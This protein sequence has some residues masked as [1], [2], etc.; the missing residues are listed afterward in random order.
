MIEKCMPGI[1]KLDLEKEMAHMGW[2]DPR[3][4]VT[5]T[6]GRFLYPRSTYRF[7]LL[8]SLDY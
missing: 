5:G 6:W 7:P 2:H 8:P 4:E 3:T 1:V